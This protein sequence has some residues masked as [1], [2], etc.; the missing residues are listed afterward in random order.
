MKKKMMMMMMNMNTKKK[1]TKKSQ[2]SKMRKIEKK[3]F[4]T[5]QKATL[6]TGTVCHDV[7]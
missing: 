1:K 6:S 5:D 3:L 2:K 7:L 4:Q